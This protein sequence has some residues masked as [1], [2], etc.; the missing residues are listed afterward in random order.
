M[1][2]PTRSPK[3]IIASLLRRS[4]YRGCTGQISYH[5]CNRRSLQIFAPADDARF[6]YPVNAQGM[7]IVLDSN[8]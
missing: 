2:T 3:Q 4:E 8:I 5:G 7:R 1:K 6:A